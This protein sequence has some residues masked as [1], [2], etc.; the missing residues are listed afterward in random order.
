[1]KEVLAVATSAL[2]VAASV[3]AAVFFLARSAYR[4]GRFLEMLRT[5]ISDNQRKI[6]EMEGYLART[7]SYRGRGSRAEADEESV[8]LYAKNDLVP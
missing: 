7:G 2:A 4:T 6:A 5:A 8:N 1:M 3:S